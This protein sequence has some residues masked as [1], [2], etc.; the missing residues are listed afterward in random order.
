MPDLEQRLAAERDAFFAGLKPPEITTLRVR[1]TARRRRRRAVIAGSALACALAVAVGV[2][3]AG[4]GPGPNPQPPAATPTTTSTGNRPEW[5]GGGLTVLGLA[6]PALSLPGELRDVEF[7]DG[8]RGYALS[9]DCPNSAKACQLG[10]ATTTD[11]GLT[12]ANG[13]LPSGTAQPDALPELVPVGDAGLVLTGDVPRYSPDGGRTWSTRPLPGTLPT[14]DALPDGARLI[15]PACATG[16]LDSWLPDGARARLA[17]QPELAVCW[18]AP[19]A[20]ADGQWWVG[21]RTPGGIPAAAVSRNRGATWTVR[22]FAGPEGSWAK[23]ATLGGYVYATVVTGEPSEAAT[24]SLTAIYRSTDA[25]GTFA[26][27]GDPAGEDGLAGDLVPLLDGR[28]LRA[29]PGWL[30]SDPSGRNFREPSNELP[31][32]GKMRRTGG[33]WVAYNLFN[34]GWAA[35]SADGT[36]WHKITVV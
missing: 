28:L 7:V 1:A 4:I 33:G 6:S 15:A 17:H 31:W 32:V 18:V 20:T 24:V 36:T 26:P 22:T 19:T 8:R 9:A 13:E 21:G 29:G 2:G 10:F 16:G 5:T 3:A 27:F 14:V 35:F 25:G 30:L 11:A 23:V 34:S 12:W